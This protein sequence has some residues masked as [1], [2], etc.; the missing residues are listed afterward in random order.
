MSLIT[1][2]LGLFGMPALI[3]VY[4]GDLP[5]VKQY[6]LAF[7][8]VMS[9]GTTTVA[10]AF[11]FDPYVH[12]IEK[13]PI[14]QC[15]AKIDLSSGIAATAEN[16]TSAT[17][18]TIPPVSNES[19]DASQSEETHPS[20]APMLDPER[21]TG[22]LKSISSDQSFLIE[23]EKPYLLRAITKNILLMTVETVF[24]PNKDIQPY[25]GYRPIANFAAK[26]KALYVH[27]ELL[28]DETLRKQM[29]FLL[30]TKERPKE[31]EDDD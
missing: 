25:D 31:E 2:G 15:H 7:A 3:S 22:E 17:D 8:A 13:I 14:R 6:A 24:D 18:T 19:P 27:P 11:V 4:S 30:K 16:G 23:P 20:S 1:C 26:N 29:Q 10:L 9:G 12:T 5:L 28:F 21:I